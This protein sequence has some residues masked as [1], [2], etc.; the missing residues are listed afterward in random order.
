MPILMCCAAAVME[1]LQ[2][3]LPAYFFCMP[4]VFHYL[5]VG[6][7]HAIP[8]ACTFYWQACLCAKRRLTRRYVMTH[9][10]YSVPDQQAVLI[11]A[12]LQG[13]DHRLT[14]ALA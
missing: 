3:A 6:S 2:L 12:P 11:W 8:S 1:A 4:S 7:R 14:T 13:F 5:L 10:A 9:G